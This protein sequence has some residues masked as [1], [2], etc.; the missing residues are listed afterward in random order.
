MYP[1]SRKFP[2]TPDN[3]YILVNQGSQEQQQYPQGIRYHNAHNLHISFDQLA[4]GSKK[5]Y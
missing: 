5:I 3:E 2:N 1:P 4:D